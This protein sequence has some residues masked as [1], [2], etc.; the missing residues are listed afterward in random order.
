MRKN[1]AGQRIGGQLI[2]AAD[3]TAFTG[4]VTVYVC[5]DAGSQA[6]GSVGSGACTHE[7]NGYHTYAPA[8]A[9]TNYNLIAFTFTGS[10]AIPVTVQVFTISFD[11]H[12]TVRLG[13]TA[14]PN[15]AA[16]AAGG[17]PIS[18]AGGLNLDAQLANTNEVTAARMGALTDWINGGRLDLILDIIAAD[19]VNLDGA[20]MRGTDNAALASVCTEARL[21]ELGAL[22][23]P[24]DIDTLLTRIVGT[25]LAGNHTAQSAD[26]TPAAVKTAIE[27]AGSHLALIKAITDQI[28]FTVANRIDANALQVGDKTGYAIGA[29]GI[30]AAAFAANAIAAAGLAADA[31][32]EI[33]DE[34]VEGT[35]TL[36]QALRL[37]L[38]AL[39]GKSSGGGTATVVFRD[40]GDTKNRISA[41]VDGDGNRT[42]VGTRD[43]T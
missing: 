13:V 18:D 21:G 38:A 20:T 11:P 28:V 17:L 1:V 29:G 12:D 22:N 9:E 30:A 31:V 25:L 2:T 36:R 6:A 14:L 15:A 3:G 40:I 8:Q 34:V 26:H 39:T 42:A 23:L 32:D 33:L 24:A 41:T 27:A 43:G 37:L 5:G 10:G 4:A 35:T 7:G 16:D 19:V